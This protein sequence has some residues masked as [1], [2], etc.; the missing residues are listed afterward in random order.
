[1][2]LH[3]IIWVLKSYHLKPKMN[4]LFLI[5]Q[6][7]GIV[8]KN[9]NPQKSSN[10]WG[11]LFKLIILIYENVYSFNICHKVS[12]NSTKPCCATDEINNV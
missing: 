11:L 5:L 1:M 9:N 12:F 4:D 7:S 2:D 10:L 6:N 8:V 3:C